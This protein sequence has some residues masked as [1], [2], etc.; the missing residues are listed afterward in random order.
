MIA[1]PFACL[2]DFCVVSSLI[3]IINLIDV[4]RCE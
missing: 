1:Y 3:M 2:Y 4:S